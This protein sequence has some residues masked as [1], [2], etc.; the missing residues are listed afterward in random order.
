MQVALAGSQAASP[1]TVSGFQQTSRM[2]LSDATKVQTLSLSVKQL[3]PD[4]RFG[5]FWVGLRSGS[6]VFWQNRSH[7]SLEAVSIHY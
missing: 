5:S 1:Y 7:L 6:M 4:G 2:W 3:S